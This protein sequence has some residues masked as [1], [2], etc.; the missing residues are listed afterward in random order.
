MDEVPEIASTEDTRAGSGEF[1]AGLATSLRKGSMERKLAVLDVIN[2]S[3]QGEVR[4]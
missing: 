1:N 2:M 4:I 3:A